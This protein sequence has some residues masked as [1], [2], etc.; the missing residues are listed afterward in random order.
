M[1]ETVPMLVALAAMLPLMIYVMW[2]DLRSLRIP[3]WV[4]LAVL[5]VFVVT[6]LW[7]LPLD[8]FLW[9]L[10]Q[11]LVFLLLGFAVF[12]VGRGS[13]GGGDMKLIAALVPFIAGA[14]ALFVLVI[15]AIVTCTGLLAHSLARAFL[16]H[17]RTGWR[18]LDQSTY[19]PVGVILGL[20]I[21]I[22]LGVEVA[23]RFRGHAA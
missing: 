13:V 23:D 8:A 7:G 12:A 4:V 5:A 16:R 9:R 6:G 3:N 14:H 22:Y 2:S 18:A 1:M 17:R 10:G 20:T 11:G 15:Y 19:V 21:L